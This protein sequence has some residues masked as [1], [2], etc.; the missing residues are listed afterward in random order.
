M[1]LGLNTQRA[2][3]TS[4]PKNAFVCSISIAISANN[5]HVKFQHVCIDYRY[6]NYLFDCFSKF[7]SSRSEPWRKLARVH[8]RGWDTSL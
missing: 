6:L 1:L 4:C 7:F 5:L 8:A 2:V 3:D